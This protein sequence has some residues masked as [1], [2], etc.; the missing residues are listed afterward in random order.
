[1]KIILYRDGRPGTAVC[2]PG[3]YPEAELEELL[4]GETEMN[5]ISARLKLVTA[6][7]DGEA[8]RPARYRLDRLGQ[9]PLLVAGDAAVIAVRPDGTIT[10]VTVRDLRAMEGRMVCGA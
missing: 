4:G 3:E 7:E 2:L 8:R 6:A 5:S 1:M 9:G 10:D